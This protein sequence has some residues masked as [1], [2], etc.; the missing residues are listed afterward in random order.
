MKPW[1]ALIILACAAVAQTPDLKTASGYPKMVQQQVTDWIEGAAAKMPEAEYAFKPDPAVRSFGQIIGHIADANYL[2]C[3]SVLKEDN[4]SKDIEKTKNTKPDLTSAL[5]GAFAYCSRA[6]GAL[7]D[8]NANEI[9]ESFGQERNKLGILW[10]NASHNLEHYGNLV[11]YMRSK[12]V[13]PP[14]SSPK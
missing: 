3:S 1:G 2:F 12:G 14:S 6:Y 7:T 5:H 8:A 10:F 13:I 11:V 9:V 4:P